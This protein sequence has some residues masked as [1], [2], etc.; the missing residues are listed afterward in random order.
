MP[1]KL[2]RYLLLAIFVSFAIFGFIHP[3][4]IPAAINN[5]IWSLSFIW[6]QTG[7]T[8][9]LD[10][11]SPPTTHKHAGLLLAHHFLRHGDLDHALENLLPLIEVS[12]P[13]AID[14]LAETLYLQEDYKAAI[15]IWLVMKN[16][17]SLEWA[18]HDL[19]GKNL[20]GLGAF[21]WRNACKLKPEIY[22]RNLVGK[23]NNAN[24][25]R[26][27]NYLHEAIEEYKEVAEEFP[28]D[29][30]SFYELAWAYWLDNQPEQAINSI[31]KAM[32]INPEEINFVLRSGFIF[33]D[34][35]LLKKALQAYQK[36]LTINPDHPEGL[37]AVKRLSNPD[38]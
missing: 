21:A 11:T 35:G 8:A 1:S 2:I 14:T 16:D 33:E 19:K 10:D 27:S 24:V 34:S 4:G 29:G 12:D 9:R 37:K 15:E 28:E 22:C 17:K 20:N 13:I 30:R 7:R 18:S 5:N 31:V 26:D 23:L 25:L 36:A 3:E 6:S 38:E 32:E